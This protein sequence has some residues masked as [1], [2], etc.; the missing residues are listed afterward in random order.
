MINEKRIAPII[1]AE[2]ILKLDA[3]I[4][5]DISVIA[6][7]KLDPDDIPNIE[8]PAKGLLKY[9]CIS[10]PAIDKELP[11]INTIIVL[12]RCNS[13]KMIDSFDSPSINKIFEKFHL[14]NPPLK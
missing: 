12:G 6:T 7:N 11:A 13:L 2:I 4:P 10:K 5:D 8:G 9:V 3:N 14:R 1:A